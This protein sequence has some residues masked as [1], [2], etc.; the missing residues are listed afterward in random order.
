MSVDTLSAPEDATVVAA[1]S[2]EG[3]LVV[4]GPVTVVGSVVDDVK[5]G[6]GEMN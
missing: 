3:A 5:D 2:P 1:S 4:V 6:D